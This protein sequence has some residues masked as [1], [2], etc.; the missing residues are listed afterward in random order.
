[1]TFPDAIGSPVLSS[2]PNSASSNVAIGPDSAQSNQRLSAESEAVDTEAG[3]EVDL[4]ADPTDGLMLSPD[5]GG[6]QDDQTGPGGFLLGSHHELPE[7]PLEGLCVPSWQ[8][9]LD[10]AVS[11]FTPEGPLITHPGDPGVIPDA[12][13]VTPGSLEGCSW[14]FPD[15]SESPAQKRRK[16]GDCGATQGSTRSLSWDHLQDQRQ[17]SSAGSQCSTASDM[18]VA[19]T[20]E[21]STSAVH[22]ADAQTKVQTPSAEH[23]THSDT[24]SQELQQMM[25]MEIS[26]A[27]EAQQANQAQLQPTI[28]AVQKKGGGSAKHAKRAVAGCKGQGKR[29]A[30]SQLKGKGK[31]PAPGQGQGHH[32]GQGQG[33]RSQ[34]ASL[35]KLLPFDSLKVSLEWMR[36]LQVSTG[37]L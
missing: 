26:S 18:A 32:V 16:P 14:D 21:K 33:Q 27:V 22:L 28:A 1:M 34:G 2:A 25:M 9:L 4:L 7:D 30:A 17:I 20:F 13:Q 24:L 3:R 8:E 11:H 12:C 31:A 10:E 29:T 35:G 15:L 36:E 23:G 6:D 5:L 19:C 37:R